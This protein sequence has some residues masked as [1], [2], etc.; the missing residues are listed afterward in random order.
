MYDELEEKGYCVPGFAS[1]CTDGYTM[2]QFTA[3]RA[4]PITTTCQPRITESRTW[5]GTTLSGATTRQHT[6]P[7][8]QFPPGPTATA[9]VAPNMHPAA[10]P[11]TPSPGDAL[12][13][14]HCPTRNALCRT[15]PA[16]QDACTITMLDTATS[17]TTASSDCVTYANKGPL[18]IP[19]ASSRLDCTGDALGAMVGLQ[20]PQQQPMSDSPQQNAVQARHDND[21]AAAATAACS[22]VDLLLVPQPLES[23][24][25]MAP[26][27]EI[28][29]CSAIAAATIQKTTAASSAANHA[30]NSTGSRAHTSYF[31]KPHNNHCATG[32]PRPMPLT[33][34][35]SITAPALATAGHGAYLKLQ[36]RNTPVRVKM[37]EYT[38]YKATNWHDSTPRMAIAPVQDGPE[39]TTSIV[40][41]TGAALDFNGLCAAALKAE[42]DSQQTAANV[43]AALRAPPHK[44]SSK[45]VP[46]SCSRRSMCQ[47]LGT[48]MLQMLAPINA[49]GECDEHL[50]KGS[51]RLANWQQ[52]SNSTTTMAKSAQVKK[53]SGSPCTTKAIFNGVPPANGRKPYPTANSWMV[54]SKCSLLDLL[55][56]PCQSRPPA[57][58]TCRQS[59]SCL[60]S[61]ASQ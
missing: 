25:R 28:L 41:T 45:Q 2:Q 14:L 6:H 51:L 60:A 38:P 34:L 3:G 1:A 18:S 16:P 12:N 9:V 54:R 40:D 58:D 19:K 5:Q 52:N 43:A 23:Q 29:A 15:K 46:G 49:G 24:Q 30:R 7:V 27:D 11:S 50:N 36:K 33:M 17:S 31:P 42:T 37:K 20:T 56:R 48:Q 8:E 21:T 35:P 22:S 4:K 26:P 53:S 47:A 57:G 13:T 61:R 55:L 59:W 32:K 39:A 10:T 44:T